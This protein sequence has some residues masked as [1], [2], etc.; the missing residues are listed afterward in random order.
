MVICCMKVFYEKKH[1]R[2][3]DSIK[4]FNRNREVN[5]LTNHGKINLITLQGA[6]DSQVL[7]THDKSYQPLLLDKAYAISSFCMEGF[8]QRLLCTHK[9]CLLNFAHSQ[10]SWKVVNLHQINGILKHP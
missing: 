3:H 5:S 8:F 6:F 4:I 10:K 1:S 9:N 7:S 2:F